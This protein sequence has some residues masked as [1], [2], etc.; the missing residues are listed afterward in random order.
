MKKFHLKSLVAGILIGSVGITTAFAAGGIKKANFSNTTVTLDGKQIPLNNSLV[1]IVKDGEKDSKLYMPVREIL[2][3]IGYDVNWNEK[4][5]SVDLTSSKNISKSN[6]ENVEENVIMALRSQGDRI[7]SSG[8]FEAKDNQTLVLEIN[9]NIDGNVNLYFFNPKG[10]QVE[11]FAIGSAN[12]SEEIKLSKGRW[13]YNCT[14]SY[15]AGG[16]IEIIG[17][18]K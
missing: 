12:T 14:G 8:F 11:A 6:S 1:S 16:E 15:K 17:K 9:S 7:I 2:E 10:Q 13:A 4:N 5:N 3:H 18:I